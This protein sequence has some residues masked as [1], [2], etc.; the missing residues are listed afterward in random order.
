MPVEMP[1]S[2]TGAFFSGCTR[3][4]PL[5]GKHQRRVEAKAGAATAFGALVPKFA[6]EYTR[7]GRKLRRMSETA[8]LLGWRAGGDPE[9]ISGSL[10]ARWRDRPVA[11]IDRR[12]IRSVVAEAQEHGVPGSERRSRGPTKSRARALLVA[13]STF[14]RW[15]LREE[16]AAANPCR[17]VPRPEPPQARDRVLTDAEIVA[18]W[19]AC[20]KVGEPFE[21]ALKLLLLTGCRLSEVAGMRFAELS[22]DFATWSIPGARTKNA[23]P[24]VVA[25][26]PLA[27]E[28]LASVR[29]VE[30][31]LAFTTSGRTPISGWSKCKRRLD[32]LMGSPPPW[33]LHDLRRTAASGMQRLGV[34]T[35]VVERALNHVS[36][37]FAGVAGVYQRD[38]MLDDTRAALLRWSQHV[39][40]LVSGDG[41]GKVLQLRG[42]RGGKTP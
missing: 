34:R 13:L 29:R 6:A 3:G 38:P 11:E 2:S 32:A 18:F 35:E 26:S 25:L 28:V 1:T 24:H 7:R 20:D 16:Y 31:G 40:G 42:R 21:Q 15:C 33:R 41:G 27:R 5:A 19:R 17:D 36:G 23:R 39:T 37:S 14:F 30:G 22:D 4:R 8:R 12:E 10:C 9:V